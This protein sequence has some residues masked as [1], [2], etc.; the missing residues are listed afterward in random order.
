MIN[1][2]LIEE[3]LG[4]ALLAGAE[5]CELFAEETYRCH[6]KYSGGQVER[7]IS[8][9]ERGAGLRVFVGG[10][11]FYASTSDVEKPSL[12]KAARAAASAAKAG[13]KKPSAITLSKCT[14]ADRHPVMVDPAGVSLDEKLALVKRADSAARG[15]SSLI[16]QVEINYADERQLVTIANSLGLMAEDKRVRTRIHVTAVASKGGENQV[17]M[18]SVGASAGFELYQAEDAA[19]CAVEA[20]RSAAVMIDAG[21]SSGGKMDV[22]IENG[23]GGVIFHEA[24]GH[25]LEAYA[26]SQKA[27]I[28]ADKMGQKIASEMVSLIDDGTIPNAWG[29]SNIDDEGTP[30]QRTVLIDKGILRSFMVDILSGRKLNLEPTGNGRR[31]SYSFAPVSRM[32]NTFILPGESSLK[33]MVGKTESGLYAKKLGGGSVNPATGDFNFAVLEGYLIK[34]GKIEGPVRGATLIGNGADILTKIDMVGKE[35]K[36]APGVCGA[37]SGGVPVNVGQPQL[38]VQGLVVGGRSEGR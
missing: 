8:G 19:R 33:E 37:K 38:R 24:C 1:K 12:L 3:V 27:S 21:Y 2:S 35:L 7:S 4:E 30:T 34:G 11:S 6:V 10:N 29:S 32:R 20:A 13:G 22:V 15:H 18:E 14:F 16:S 9:V 5:F 28:Y 26:I 31:Q 36:L 17:G 25:G 23:F